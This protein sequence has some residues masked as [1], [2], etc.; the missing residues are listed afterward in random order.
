MGLGMHA[1]KLSLRERVLSFVSVT[2][3]EEDIVPQIKFDAN[4]L[5]MLKFSL[6]NIIDI[7]WDG[8]NRVR[9]T[10]VGSPALFDRKLDAYFQ[11]AW[12]KLH[13][14]KHNETGYSY[15]EI[16]YQLV[17]PR[18]YESDSVLSDMVRKYGDELIIHTVKD[19]TSSRRILD[20]SQTF[21]YRQVSPNIEV[22]TY[23]DGSQST[24]N[25]CRNIEQKFYKTSRWQNESIGHD[26]EIAR[27]IVRQ[28][29]SRAVGGGFSD[30]DISL[31]ND[32]FLV[33]MRN[34]PRT[35][36]EKLEK[37]LHKALSDGD[38]EQVG[39]LLSE[40]ERRG[41]V[42]RPLLAEKSEVNNILMQ[43]ADKILEPARHQ[44]SRQKPVQ[45]K[46]ETAESIYPAKMKTMF[47]LYAM[48]SNWKLA[49]AIEMFLDTDNYDVFRIAM[50]YLN[51][52]QDDLLRNKLKENAREIGLQRFKDEIMDS[53]T[54][55]NYLG[56]RQAI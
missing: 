40:D 9:L 20:G 15:D 1:K 4:D 31:D 54:K 45:A 33:I 6:D 52:V 35:P 38:I 32:N 41:S 47:Q 21:N 53:Y 23:E 46:N 44:Y 11:D 24:E 30:A 29:A 7:N 17:L 48:S 49:E 25:F 18:T 8:S 55:V 2:I 56:D 36:A 14:L 26:V 5:P 43:L 39:S 51:T 22:T 50:A 10:R 28:E 19:K 42:L 37:A 34:K 3:K 12:N 13:E 16:K 27:D